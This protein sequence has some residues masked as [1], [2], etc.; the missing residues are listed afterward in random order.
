M[1][2]MVSQAMA[3]S[4]WRFYPPVPFTWTFTLQKVLWQSVPG[5]LDWL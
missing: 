1:G 2:G 5:T 3:L 4:R